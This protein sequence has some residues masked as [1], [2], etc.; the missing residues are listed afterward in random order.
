MYMYIQLSATPH[1]LHNAI[2]DTC[3]SSV[4]VEIEPYSTVFVKHISVFTLALKTTRAS[5]Q[6]VQIVFL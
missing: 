4:Y 1:P 5:G 3:G 6:N 2:D